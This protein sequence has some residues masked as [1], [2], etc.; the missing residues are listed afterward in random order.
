[1]QKIHNYYLVPGKAY[2]VRPG[3]QFVKVP[4]KPFTASQMRRTCTEEDHV[5]EMNHPKDNLMWEYYRGCNCK[6]AR[7][8][9]AD[10]LIIHDFHTN[11]FGLE[12]SPRYTYYGQATRPGED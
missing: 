4:D 7:Q 10:L 8:R 1:M 5:F 3:A 9:P 11:T 12:M 6:I 2:I